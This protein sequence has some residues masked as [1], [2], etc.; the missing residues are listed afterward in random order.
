MT[1]A[2]YRFRCR[3]YRTISALCRAGFQGARI[4]Q[5]S[6]RHVYP[7][8]PA[9]IQKGDTS[10]KHRLKSVA[11]PTRDSDDTGN[12]LIQNSRLPGHYLQRYRVPSAHLQTMHWSGIFPS[13]FISSRSCLCFS[14]GTRV[15]AV[16]MPE[17][18]TAGTPMPGKT[19]S[20][21]QRSPSMPVKPTKKDDN[22]RMSNMSKQL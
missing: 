11:N 12:K 1:G 7:Q 8:Y 20:P 14:S 21:Q 22:R 2:E 13:A 19:L 5:V 16:V 17:A 9:R 3:Y 6:S 4:S 10:G 18:A 15:L